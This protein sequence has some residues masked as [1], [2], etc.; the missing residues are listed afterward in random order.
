MNEGTKEQFQ[1]ALENSYV[2][3]LGTAARDLYQIYKEL[4]NAGFDK[5]EAMALLITMIQNIK[6]QEQR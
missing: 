5:T 2:K 6:N 4:Q 1:K 3:E